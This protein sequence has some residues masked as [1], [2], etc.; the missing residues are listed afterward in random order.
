VR[1]AHALGTA[2]REKA[3]SSVVRG[4]VLRSVQRPVHVNRHSTRRSQGRAG[5]GGAVDS[6][7]RSGKPA[8]AGGT[9]TGAWSDGRMHGSPRVTALLASRHGEVVRDALKREGGRGHRPRREVTRAPVGLPVRRSEVAE[10]GRRCL[11]SNK[12]GRSAPKRV[13]VRVNGGLARGGDRRESVGDHLER[14]RTR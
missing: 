3:R 7:S 2:R 11:V 13:A 10:V 4:H 8:K 6:V 9:G 1:Q 5:Q 14:R 12:L